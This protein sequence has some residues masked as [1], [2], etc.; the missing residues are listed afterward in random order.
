MHHVVSGMHVDNRRPNADEGAM[1]YHISPR[2]LLGLKGETL[3]VLPAASLAPPA[4]GY[5]GPSINSMDGSGPGST[6]IPPA[7]SRQSGP[8]ATPLRE[9]AGIPSRRRGRSSCASPQSKPSCLPGHSGKE[10]STGR[11]VLPVA[12]TRGAASGTPSTKRRGDRLADEQPA[13]RRAPTPNVEP[14]I[15]ETYFSAS[16]D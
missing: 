13:M 6:V 7:P 12:S 14:R 10:V 2:N 9:A 4:S 3:P 15:A 16:L 11:V 1:H 8:Y 5:A